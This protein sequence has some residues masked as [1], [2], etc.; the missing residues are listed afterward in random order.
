MRLPAT[1]SES[2]QLGGFVVD[3]ASQ[4]APGVLVI[5]GGIAQEENCLLTLSPPDHEVSNSNPRNLQ[6]A[7]LHWPEGLQQLGGEEKTNRTSSQPVFILHLSPPPPRQARR[8]LRPL[9]PGWRGAL[10]LVPRAAGHITSFEIE[11]MANSS[12]RIPNPVFFCLH[13]TFIILED[14]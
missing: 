7:E 1:R 4:Y 8:P 3:I 6:S 5:T 13:P 9:G 11:L 10:G 12:Y 2:N 14:I